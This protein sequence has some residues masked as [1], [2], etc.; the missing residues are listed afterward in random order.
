MRDLSVTI[1]EVPE[2]SGVVSSY[3]AGEGIR[4]SGASFWV[5]GSSQRSLRKTP[6]V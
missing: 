5:I 1:I 6:I 2:S 4:A 3:Q